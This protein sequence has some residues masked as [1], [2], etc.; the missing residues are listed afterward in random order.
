MEEKEYP[1]ACSQVV[2]VVFTACLFPFQLL[3]SMADWRSLQQFYLNPRCVTADICF[4]YLGLSALEFSSVTNI[5][6]VLSIPLL[7][8]CGILLDHL[9][10]PSVVLFMNLSCSTGAALHLL[11]SYFGQYHF[12]IV[13]FITIGRAL[14]VFVN[15]MH[16][17]IIQYVS[18][19][20]FPPRIQPFVIGLLYAAYSS[21]FLMARLVL[22]E[23]ALLPE[24]KETFWVMTITTFGAFIFG[25]LIVVVFKLLPDIAD[26]EKKKKSQNIARSISCG[27]FLTPL[28]KSYP[29]F[30]FIAVILA[31][32]SCIQHVVM[33]DIQL[34]KWFGVHSFWIQINDVNK[35]SKYLGQAVVLPFFGFAMLYS[36]SKVMVGLFSC[37]LEILSVLFISLSFGGPIIFNV[38]DGLVLPI[39]TM[40]F[41][42]ILN[43]YTS[44]EHLGIASTLTSALSVILFGIGNSVSG[45]SSDESKEER[46]ILL[47]GIMTVF[48]ATICCILWKWVK[49]KD[50]TNNH[51]RLQSEQKE[52]DH[53]IEICGKV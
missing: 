51:K 3:A 27:H 18:M 4:P 9:G 1:R 53:G 5:S 28:K 23:T 12:L 21:S 11:A 19:R 46:V 32:H 49:A 39:N 48:L 20:F 14:L 52:K 30:W 24:P 36:P 45:W 22:P 2:L 33:N 8:I 34:I 41:I 42:F 38:L 13:F 17:A 10:L 47:L 29:E 40:L 26:L 37:V 50:P 25:A 44:K 16:Y 6:S 43:D 35:L 7:L 15:F 31:N